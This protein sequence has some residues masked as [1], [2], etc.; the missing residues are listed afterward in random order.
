MA[1]KSEGADRKTE[2]QVSKTSTKTGP[3]YGLEALL[4]II[5]ILGTSF[6]A[7]LWIDSHYA[8]TTHVENVENHVEN[9]ENRLEL[10][11]IDDQL[12]NIRN[13]IFTYEEQLKI[14][15]DEETARVLLRS[16]EK[17]EEDLKLEKQSLLH[18]LRNQ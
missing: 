17:K 12:Q 1:G 14:N 10:K 13:Q 18:A 3:R 16:L 11:I 2:D 4:G 6:T 8:R 9:V 15:K 5:A 7:F